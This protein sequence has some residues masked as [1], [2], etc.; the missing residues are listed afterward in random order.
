[1]FYLAGC[2]CPTC[3]STIHYS[4]NGRPFPTNWGK[5]PEIQT[6]DYRPLP[7]GYGHGSSTLNGWIMENTRKD[8][9][10]RANNLP[11]NILLDMIVDPLSVW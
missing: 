9:Q 3:E 2:C 11:D 7:H 8:L 10:H 5:P 4:P 6:K 1:M